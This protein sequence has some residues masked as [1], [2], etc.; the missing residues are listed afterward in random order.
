MD[1][2]SRASHLYERMDADGAS[3]DIGLVHQ[4]PVNDKNLSHTPAELMLL[5]AYKSTKFLF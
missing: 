3:G 2:K 5:S 4:Q 1:F